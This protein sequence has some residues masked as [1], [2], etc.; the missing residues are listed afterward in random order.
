MLV[1]RSGNFS[2]CLRETDK[3][4]DALARFAQTTNME[5]VCYNKVYAYLNL[6]KRIVHDFYIIIDFIFPSNQKTKS[7]VPCKNCNK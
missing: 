4:N 2:C 1:Q 6:V 3:A 7:I 5:M